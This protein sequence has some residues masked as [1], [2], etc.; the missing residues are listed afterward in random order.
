MRRLAVVV[1]IHWC[2]ILAF[3]QSPTDDLGVQ[4]ASPRQPAIPSQQF[5][6]NGRQTRQVTP[7]TPFWKMDFS[8]LA[9]AQK[10]ISAQDTDQ[11]FHAPTINTGNLLAMLPPSPFPTAKPEPIPTRWPKARIEQIPTTWPALK[12]QPAES[13]LTTLSK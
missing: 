3:S 9:S 2:S 11:Q 13:R 12:M 7:S 1:V 6:F 10:Q 5:D 8:S 4:Q